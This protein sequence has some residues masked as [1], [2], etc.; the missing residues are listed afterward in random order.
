MKTHTIGLIWSANV[1][2]STI[3]NRLIGTHRAIITDIAGTTRDI[4]REQWSFLWYQDVVIQDTPWLIQF[5]EEIPYIQ[6]VIDS[7]DLLLFVVDHK[8]WLSTREHQI[9]QM[10][11]QSGKKSDTVLLINK[12]DRRVFTDYQWVLAD[13]YELWFEHM[14]AISAKEWNNIDKLRQLIQSF[15]WESDIVIPDEPDQDEFEEE[16][17]REEAFVPSIIDPKQ[18]IKL[19]II[20]KPNAGK[21]TLINQFAGKDLSKVSPVAWTTLD[22]IV[23]SIHRGA[24]EYEL[25]DTVGIRRKTKMLTLEKIAYQKTL[26]MLKYI[27]PLIIFLIDLVEGIT[28]RDQTLLSEIDELWLPLIL[29]YNKAD[30]FTT[31]EL[32]MRIKSFS[33]LL[34]HLKHI[35]T[36]SISG[37]TGQWLDTILKKTKVLHQSLAQEFKTSDLN[38]LVSKAFLVNPPKFPKNKIC[39]IFYMT[40]ISSSPLTFKCFVN[41]A[42]KSNFAF[43]RWLENVLRKQYGLG[44]IPIVFDFVTSHK[45]RGT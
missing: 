42:Q 8:Q 16:G 37:L 14:L 31:K 27:R 23:T 43:E 10:I 22:Y 34:R 40:Q 41:D 21:S 24:Q 4:L 38:K 20:G 45:K 29:I 2:K 9:K 44:W 13:Y 5:D 32:A 1:G 28:H 30:L 35:S 3:F 11:L 19:A 15:L 36:L 25:Y 7:S 39:K 12:A 33:P 17:E 18:P 6:K 26:T